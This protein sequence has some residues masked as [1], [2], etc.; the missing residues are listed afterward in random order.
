[1]RGDIGLGKNWREHDCGGG[2]EGFYN[3]EDMER[4]CALESLRYQGLVRHGVLRSPRLE[5][6]CRVVVRDGKDISGVDE[7]NESDTI[8]VVDGD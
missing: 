1:L 7:V 2:V 5:L 3:G 8:V 4:D 6:R